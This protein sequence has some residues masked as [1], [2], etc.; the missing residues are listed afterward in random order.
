MVSK[1]LRI[2][3]IATLL[4]PPPTCL[5]QK[6]QAT[7]NISVK[8]VRVEV[9]VLVKDK[10]TGMPVDGLTKGDFVVHEGGKRRAVT[11]FR[12][13]E[14]SDEPLDLYLMVEVSYFTKGV[15]P[16]LSW[17]L[18]KAFSC[19]RPGD[20][21]TVGYFDYARAAIVRRG[22]SSPDSLRQAL[23]E[24]A[25]VERREFGSRKGRKREEGIRRTRRRT[26]LDQAMPSSTT[27][28]AGEGSRQRACLLVML[29][30][31]ASSPGTTGGRS[32]AGQ[33]PS[34]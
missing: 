19:I 22:I 32:E 14:R 18:P 5:A 16:G 29:R 31:F 12:A 7:E 1:R 9:P 33:T 21:I 30:H 3:L 20:T 15:A 2:L 4:L 27:S 28:A 8:V 10:R 25:A 17:S 6:M 26:S 11:Y 24:V 23:D 13:G 34:S